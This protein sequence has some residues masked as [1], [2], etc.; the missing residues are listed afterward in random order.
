MRLTEELPLVEG[1]T[2]LAGLEQ[3][4]TAVGAIELRQCL[5]D[6]HTFLAGPGLDMQ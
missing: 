3:G 5:A 4:K 2:R 6:F 1:H